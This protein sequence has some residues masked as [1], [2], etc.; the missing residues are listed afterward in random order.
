MDRGR[1]LAGRRI[2]GGGRRGAWPSSSG[3]S[4]ARAAGSAGR[5]FTGAASSTA[6]PSRARLLRSMARKS[7]C[8]RRARASRLISSTSAR[9][10][11]VQGLVVGGCASGAGRSASE[12]PLALPTSSP[13][14]LPNCAA[15]D[16][17][18]PRPRPRAISSGYLCCGGRSG[19]VL[20][21]TRRW[22][23][24]L[25]RPQRYCHS[26]IR[27]RCASPSPLD[28]EALRRDWLPLLVSNAASTVP[29]TGKRAAA[30]LLRAVTDR[31]A[32]C[33]RKAEKHCEC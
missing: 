20:V 21:A 19:V 7:G 27:A 13:I 3:G 8:A 16:L 15:A 18:R 24:V 26:P 4:N 32:V 14:S 9:S 23:F 10:S 30:A 29:T 5:P 6:W 22:L 11:S 17:P 28:G 33:G 2:G 1:F 25:R 12:S 31:C